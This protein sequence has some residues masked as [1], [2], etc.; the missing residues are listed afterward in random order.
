MSAD[1][2][3]V[4]LIDDWL[5]PDITDLLNFVPVDWSIT[6]SLTDYEIYMYTSRYNWLDND[7]LENSERWP[8]VQSTVTL[9]SSCSTSGILREDW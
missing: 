6:A 8:S 9:L 1:G 2:L 3:A 7:C 5:G 4:A